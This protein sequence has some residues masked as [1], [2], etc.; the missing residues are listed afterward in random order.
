MSSEVVDPFDDC[1][2]AEL[3]TRRSEK[4]AIYPADVL[5]AF[6]AEMD[7]VLAAP[8]KRALI[9]AIDRGDT[10]YAHPLASS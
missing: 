7:V 6:V 5:P 8:I 10:G 1:S 4:W 2:L 3:R 9:D